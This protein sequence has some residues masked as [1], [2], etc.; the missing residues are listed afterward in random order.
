MFMDKVNPEY[1]VDVN[2][3]ELKALVKKQVESEGY[4]VES[5]TVKTK[6]VPF[7][8]GDMLHGYTDYRQE[9][10]GFHVKARKIS[11]QRE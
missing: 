3:E 10:D 6:S 11:K 4:E 7:Q 1:N 2:L 9:F 8:V 5:I